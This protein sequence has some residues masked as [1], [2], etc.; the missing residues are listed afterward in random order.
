MKKLIPVLVLLLGGCVSTEMKGYVGKDIREVILTNGQP[1]GT[2]D[3]GDGSRA[4]QFM[5]GG[6]N[7]TSVTSSRTTQVN[8]D[9]LGKS[10]VQS[11][12]N[13]VIS[14]GC[15]ISYITRWDEAKNGWIVF[16]YRYPNRAIC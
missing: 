7:Q 5:W 10:S 2:M 3:M 11:S 14:N 8:S 9:W 6:S 12:G 13:A 4:F 1:M 15:V 16:D